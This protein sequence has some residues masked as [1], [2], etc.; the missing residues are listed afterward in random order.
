MPFV[1]Q[2]V[3]GAAIGVA[4]LWWAWRVVDGETLLLELREF[5]W[6][7]LAPVLSILLLRAAVRAYRWRLLF[8]NDPPGL[9]RLFF[10]ETTGI[11]VNSIAPVRVLA[12]PVQFAYLT[13]R[14]GHDRGTVL[15]TLI[16]VRVIDLIVT[17]SSIVVG[18]AVY[19]PS[20]QVPWEVWGGILILAIVA[21]AV[22]VASFWLPAMHRLQRWSF[23][24]TYASA[25]R[26]VAMRPR[27]L[28]AILALTL[29]HLG[30][31]GVA[32]WVIA[33]GMGIELELPLMFMLVLAIFTTGLTLP[34]LPSGLGPIEAASVFF[35]SLYGVAEEPALA[36][37]I[38]IHGAFMLPPIVIAV[39][40]IA[41][42]GLPWLRRSG[43]RASHRQ[44]PHESP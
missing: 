15:A 41:V 37:G 1:V 24:T 27:R 42:T 25:W 36:F 23:I 14:D 26:Q 28:A 32:A 19:A 13:I 8:F 29:A 34:G 43:D 16:Q 10:V 18:F 4:L 11:G 3:V 12:E 22:V 38:V 39:G 40:T 6:H 21:V 7:L 17:L 33:R 20:I 44:V 30:L 5:P 31:L 35:L 2:S 9:A